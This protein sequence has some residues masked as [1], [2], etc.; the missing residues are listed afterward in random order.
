MEVRGA[1]PSNTAKGGA[2]LN[3]NVCRKGGPAPELKPL[4]KWYA[5]DDSLAPME[6]KA[7]ACERKLHVSVNLSNVKTLDD[8]VKTFGALEAPEIGSTSTANVRE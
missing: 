8:Y 7:R 4:E 1:H 5:F 6:W 3:Y 2:A